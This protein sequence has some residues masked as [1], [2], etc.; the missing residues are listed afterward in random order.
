MGVSPVLTGRRPCHD[1]NLSIPSLGVHL[2]ASA[3]RRLHFPLD[4][5]GGYPRSGFGPRVIR[6]VSACSTSLSSKSTAYTDS[7][8]GIS[9]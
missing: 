9:T 2:G 5:H 3:S 6:S 8:I 4:A 7:V 1:I